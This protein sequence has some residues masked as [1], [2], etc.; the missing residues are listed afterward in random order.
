MRG[1]NNSDEEEART[2]IRQLIGK[3]WLELNGRVLEI[4]PDNEPEKL[5]VHGSTG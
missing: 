4:G 5:S 3:L 2:H 1:S